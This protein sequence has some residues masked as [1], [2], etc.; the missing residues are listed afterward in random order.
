MHVGGVDALLAERG[1]ERVDRGARAS[2]SS[3]AQRRRGR[4]RRHLPRDRHRHGR[5][6]DHPRRRRAEDRPARTRSACCARCSGSPQ[7]TDR[8]PLRIGASRGR[9]FAGEVG[10]PFRS[11]YTIL[12]K[13]AALAA[14]LMAKRRA[15][16]AAHDRRRARAL[17]QYLRDG[18]APAGR[19][20][21]IEG[22][23]DRRST[24]TAWRSP[25][26]PARTQ[27]LPFVGR[28][29]ELTIVSA[30]LGPVRMGFGNIVELIGEP[31]LGK[32]RLVD[33]LQAR[34]PD[35]GAHRL[36]RAV[37][38]L[39]AVLRLPRRARLA[40]RAPGER[41]RSR[42]RCADSVEALDPELLPWL[43]LLAAAARPAVEPTREVDELQPAFRRARLHGVVESP[44]DEAAGR[45][46]AARGRGRALDGRGLVRAAPPPRHAGHGQAVA[47]LRR[48]GARSRAA[49]SAAEGMPPIPA[50][51]IHLQPLPATR[52][53]S[54]S[55][56]R[57]AGRLPQ[58]EVCG[59]HRARRRQPAL[60]A[61]AGRLH[62][63]R[64]RTRRCRRASRPS[65]PRGSTGCR[66]ATA[67]CSATRRCSA[68]RSARSSSRSACRRPGRLG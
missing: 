64:R 31:G 7:A 14:R 39:D 25:A 37:R 32:S 22:A 38:G 67:R 20:K 47:D 13:T 40:A 15:R 12:G 53:A 2:S 59:D 30:A 21:G 35:L 63:A 48:R 29:R 10:A 9:V 45:A 58:H 16:P 27:R 60:P 54:W 33:E 68:R 17:P 28:E 44:A 49:S 1:A 42:R 61:G 5:R 57:P 50:M 26:R 6:Q 56:P 18:R 41:R 43:P 51:T 36:L 46:D 8:L 52:P 66:R 19:L 55:G 23:G 11:T 65:S 34:A 24:S 4:A 3:S 62:R